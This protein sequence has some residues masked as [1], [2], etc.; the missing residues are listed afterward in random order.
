MGRFLKSIKYVTIALTFPISLPL[1]LWFR[2]TRLASVKSILEP[3]DIGKPIHIFETIPAL[4]AGFPVLATI[5]PRS[6][7][8]QPVYDKLTLRQPLP[9]VGA[10]IPVTIMDIGISSSGSVPNTCEWS[11]NLDSDDTV[12]LHVSWGRNNLTPQA[13]AAG[14]MYTASLRLNGTRIGNGYLCRV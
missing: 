7:L 4:Q 3:F 5:T 12:N 11:W 8:V 6:I 10:S 9:G 13:I 2:K 1:V 14:I